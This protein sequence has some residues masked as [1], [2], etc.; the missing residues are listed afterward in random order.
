MPNSNGKAS[1]IDYSRF[2]KPLRRLYYLNE[3]STQPR[4]LRIELERGGERCLWKA[5]TSLKQM[6]ETKRYLETLWHLV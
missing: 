6:E 5:K 2:D 1:R 4:S 3:Y